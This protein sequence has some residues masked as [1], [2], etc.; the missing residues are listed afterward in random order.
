[1]SRVSCYARRCLRGHPPLLPSKSRSRQHT[2]L[3]R[4]AE[5]AARARP[6]RVGTIRAGRFRGTRASARRLCFPTRRQRGEGGW[7]P[8]MGEFQRATRRPATERSEG[9]QLGAPPERAYSRW[10]APVRPRAQMRNARGTLQLLSGVL[11]VFPQTNKAE[12]QTCLSQAS[13]CR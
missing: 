5:L 13:R 9:A 11:R 6:D 2:A 3:H 1:M 8:P 4:P 12:L 7:G 10:E